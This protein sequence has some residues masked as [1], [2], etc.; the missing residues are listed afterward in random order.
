MAYNSDMF[1]EF[2]DF[3]ASYGYSDEEFLSDDEL[4]DSSNYGLEEEE[5]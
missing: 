2:D 3:F 1:D 5:E 4:Y